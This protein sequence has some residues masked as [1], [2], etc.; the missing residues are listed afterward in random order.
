MLPPPTPEHQAG[1][2]GKGSTHQLSTPKPGSWGWWGRDVGLCGAREGG[3]LSRSY[4]EHFL[5]AK[6]Q[7]EKERGREEQ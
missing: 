6:V 7:K 3:G 5:L 4:P 2:P 1:G